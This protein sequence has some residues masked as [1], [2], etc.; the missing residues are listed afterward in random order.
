MPPHRNVDGRASPETDLARL[1]ARLGPDEDRAGREYERLRR[2]LTRF[3]DWRGA[4]PS[5]ECAD[6]TI[7]RLARKLQDTVVEDV[8]A[9]AHGIARMVLLEWQRKPARVPIDGAEHPFAM[10]DVAVDAGGLQGCFD[11][12]LAELPAE[13]RALIL[14]YYQGERAV[15][16]A[17]RRRMAEALKLSENALRSRVQRVRDRLEHCVRGCTAKTTR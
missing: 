14:D 10:P 8:S 15:K 17:N 1:L 16:I 9:Y 11:E 3:F 5:D 4:W 13:S 7:D 12:C 2:S 6:E